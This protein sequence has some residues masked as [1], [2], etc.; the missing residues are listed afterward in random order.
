MSAVGQAGTGIVMIKGMP[1]FGRLAQLNQYAV[2]LNSWEA[3]NQE[4]YD[5]AAY[6]TAGQNQL[7]FFTTGVGAGIGVLTGLAKSPEDTNMS[8]GG[9]FPSGQAY[10]MSTLEVDFQPGISSAGFA[11]T[12]LPAVGPAAV[13]IA[14]AINDTYKFYYTGFLQLVVG[15]KPYMTVGPLIRFAPARSFDVSGAMSNATTPAAALYAAALFGMARG[16]VYSLAPNNYLLAPTVN[17]NI[18]LNWI[19][20]ETVASAA[21]VFVRFGGQLFRAA[22]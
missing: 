18:T 4:M 19:T 17:F 5:S 10:I 11:A 15:S 20:V 14:S 13:A 16:P 7:N 2:M 3:I 9:Q 12:E 22:Q 21:R 6:V 1:V 8:Q